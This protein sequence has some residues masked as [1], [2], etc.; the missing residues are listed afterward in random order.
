MAQR[1]LVALGLVL[2]V[3]GVVGAQVTFERPAQRGPGAAELADLFGR[4]FQHSA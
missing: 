4:L 1:M 3:P 2:L